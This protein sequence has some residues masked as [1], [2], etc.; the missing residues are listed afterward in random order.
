MSLCRNKE[1]HPKTIPVAVFFHKQIQNYNI[2]LMNDTVSFEQLGPDI[3]H[4][5]GYANTYYV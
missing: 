1:N 5:T 2:S 3:L 4:S